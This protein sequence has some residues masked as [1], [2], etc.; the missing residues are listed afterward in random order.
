MIYTL[1]FNI[2]R[3]YVFSNQLC[4]I[5]RAGVAEEQS[6]KSSKSPVLFICICLKQVLTLPAG[7]HGVKAG[8]ELLSTVRNWLANL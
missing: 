6:Y 1:C 4:V 7:H 2:F 8:I 3:F 5:T